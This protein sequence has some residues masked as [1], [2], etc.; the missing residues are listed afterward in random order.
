MVPRCVL[1]LRPRCRRRGCTHARAQC[2][3]AG[4]LS[5]A[6]GHADDCF[7]NLN[8]VLC[9]VLLGCFGVHGSAWW[10]A[11]ARW[12]AAVANEPTTLWTLVHSSTLDLDAFQAPE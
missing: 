2:E 7:K 10:C 3:P 4:A 8:F 9:F 11:T 1:A 12:W 5:P 6:E